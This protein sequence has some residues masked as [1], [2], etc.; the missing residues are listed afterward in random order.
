MDARFQVSSEYKPFNGRPVLVWTGGNESLSAAEWEFMKKKAEPS[1]F[2]FD[3][4]E[5]GAKDYFWKPTITNEVLTFL[6]DLVIGAAS[7]GNHHF[8]ILADPRVLHAALCDEE[9]VGKI[10]TAIQ[11]QHSD[12]TPTWRVSRTYLQHV[13]VGCRV[14]ED[15]VRRPEG[16]L[17]WLSTVSYVSRFVWINGNLDKDC[18]LEDLRPCADEVP[19]AGD[20]NLYTG[21]VFWPGTYSYRDSVSAF[22]HLYSP[23]TFAIFDFSKADE[24]A[25]GRMDN[26][27]DDCHRYDVPVVLLDP[28][29]KVKRYWE[30]ADC[31]VSQI[32]KEIYRR[33]AR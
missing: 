8:V 13:L 5:S 3:F 14:N 32:F 12:E 1:F 25:S 9:H 23:L 21:E 31:E 6:R 10:K 22:Q 18:N 27:L 20:Y 33:N 26:E 19:T 30:G 15:N 4:E 7:V 29:A 11:Q 16:Q 24:T 28:P 2:I 17:P